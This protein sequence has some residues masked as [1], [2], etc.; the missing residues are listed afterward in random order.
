MSLIDSIKHHEGFRG[1]PYDDHLG[2]P[3]IGYGTKLPITEHEASLLLRHRLDRMEHEL[4]ARREDFRRLPAS[5]Q[6]ALLEAAYQLGVPGLL[7]FA[8]MWAAI[9]ERDWGRAADEA[10]DSKW[11]AQTPV[12]AEAL[13]GVLRAQA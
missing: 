11:H 10:L 9:R 12:R 2:F 6:D 13:A 4:E 7:R 8:K 3:T 1:M 5:V